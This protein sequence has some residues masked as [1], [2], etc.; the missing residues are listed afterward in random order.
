MGSLADEL[1]AQAEEKQYYQSQRPTLANWLSQIMGPPS[2]SDVLP[3]TRDPDFEKLVTTTDAQGRASHNR[4]PT[5]GGLSFAWPNMAREMVNN[6]A[7]LVDMPRA[8]LAGEIDPESQ[9]SIDRI[10]AGLVDT[11][12]AAAM[13]GKYDPSMVRM[14]AGSADNLSPAQQQADDILRMLKAGRGSEV[15]DDM[16]AAADDA[17]LFNN[18]DLPMDEASRMA[19]A[20]EMGFDYVRRSQSQSSPFN[21]TDYAM[22]VESGGD[23]MGKLDDIESYGPAMWMG[24]PD[25]DV[26]DFQKDIVRSI[27]SRDL[28]EEYNVTAS[29]LAREANPDD[30]VDSAGMWDDPELAGPVID[31]LDRMGIGGL[32]TTDGLIAWR[33]ENIRSKF[34]RFDPRLSHSANLSAITGSPLAAMGLNLPYTQEQDDQ[35]LAAYLRRVQ[36]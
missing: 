4:V 36:Q 6:G 7:G 8:A 28:Q 17:Y 30:I 34:A 15:T 13:F 1:A 3:V 12:G 24:R 29:S 10:V 19:R 33:P 32:A 11:Q 2:T 22:F 18:Y 21:D 31:D 16:L 35:S 23:A 27:R 26:T 25:S 20:Q 9:N 5:Q 14:A